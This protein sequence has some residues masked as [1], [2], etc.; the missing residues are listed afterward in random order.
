M[1]YTR[2]TITF[3]F[4]TVSAFM[5]HFDGHQTKKAGI[6]GKYGLLKSASLRK[7][8]KKIVISQRK[9]AQ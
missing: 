9:K 3:I 4:G 8:I 7:I 5:G 6:C 1:S 2:G